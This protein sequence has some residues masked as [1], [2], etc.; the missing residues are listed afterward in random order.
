MLHV[1]NSF[2]KFEAHW[3]FEERSYFEIKQLK[4]RFSPDRKFLFILFNKFNKLFNKW[5]LKTENMIQFQVN[6]TKFTCLESNRWKEGDIVLSALW[7][8]QSADFLPSVHCAKANCQKTG[9]C[10]SFSTCKHTKWSFSL[11]LFQVFS[12]SLWTR[13][14]L[15]SVLDHVSL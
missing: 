5:L 8:Q 14:P 12:Q 11:C 2:R 7:Q 1:T 4:K 9:R 3:H 15:H 10:K 13:R 6:K